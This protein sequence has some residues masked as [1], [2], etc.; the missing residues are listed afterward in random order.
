MKG[1]KMQIPQENIYTGLEIIETQNSE[2]EEFLKCNFRFPSN[3]LKEI[4]K[5][6]S[7]DPEMRDIIYN[8]PKI[9]SKELA[10]KKLSLDFMK[11]TDPNEKILEII[12]YSDLESEI[13]LQKEDFLCDRIIDKY[14]KT[15]I[16][17]I[18]LVEPYEKR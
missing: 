7:K 18:I 3:N 2:L 1:L 9:I 10:C 13:L 5:L 4:N 11:E 15:Q 6:I 16:E 8:L 12:I 17:Y 14:P